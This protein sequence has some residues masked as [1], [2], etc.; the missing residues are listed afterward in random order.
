MLSCGISRGDGYPNTYAEVPGD[1]EKLERV[2]GGRVIQAGKE[3]GPIDAIGRRFAQLI[4]RVG[5]RGQGKT[6]DMI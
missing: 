1:I 5:K 2:A 4:D 3:N 6:A